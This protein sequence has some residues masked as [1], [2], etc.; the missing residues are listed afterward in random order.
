MISRIF[1]VSFKLKQFQCIQHWKKNKQIHSIPL[2]WP[3]PI[4]CEWKYL[5]SL[6]WFCSNGFNKGPG[7]IWK[8]EEPFYSSNTPLYILRV[9]WIY[10][11]AHIGVI[12]NNLESRW[13]GWGFANMLL[14]L[15]LICDDVVFSDVINDCQYQ[16][17]LSREESAMNNLKC[18]Q[19]LQKIYL[20]KCS[21]IFSKVTEIFA[22]LN[23]NPI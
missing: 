9:S 14:L 22:P 17:A 18:L 19:R 2:F 15:F 11:T 12:L 5:R 20:W 21:L 7:K 1:A 13:E 3:K 4:F 6:T 23:K 10:E 8:Y 16:L